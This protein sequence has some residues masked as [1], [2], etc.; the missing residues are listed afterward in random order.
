MQL[1]QAQAVRAL[2]APAGCACSRRRKAAHLLL[3][4]LKWRESIG[5]QTLTMEE[6]DVE[7]KSGKLYVKVW[8]RRGHADG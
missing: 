4:T 6:F 8:K 2:H 7:L 3:S 1:L 5:L